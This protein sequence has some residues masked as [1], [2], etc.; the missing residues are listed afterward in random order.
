MTRYLAQRVLDRAWLSWDLRLENVEVKYALNGPAQISADLG[1][2]EL[3]AAGLEPW[4]SFIHVEEDGLI[5][6]SGVLMPFAYEGETVS[7]TAAG[8]TR[9]PKGIPYQGDFNLGTPVGVAIDPLDIVRHIWA[10][11]Q[12]HP[13]GNVGAIIPNL[14]TPVR[15]GSPERDVSFETDE[16]EQ[17]EFTAGPYNA[18]QWW[19][20]TDCGSEIDNLAEDTPFD[21]REAPRWNDSYT[22]VEQHVEFGYPRLGNLRTDLSFAEGE[23]LLQALV[24]VEA[25]DVYASEVI[26]LGKGEG[27]T[28]VRGRSGERVGNRLRRVLVVEDGTVATTDRAN[29]R[30]EAERL[31]RQGLLSFESVTIDARHPN[32]RLGSFA[33]GDDIPVR[34]FVPGV[35]RTLIHHRVL[36]YTWRPG[37]D[38]VEVEVDRSDT[39]QYGG[40]PA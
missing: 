7:I 2:E 12:G 19:E 4:G 31:R 39:F 36:S 25:D 8:V 14:T 27:V 37:V 26:V 33:P 34:C 28:T 29:Q 22:D 16:G 32:A 20:S 35:G 30:A 13:D 1:A 23:N 18:L 11:V 40:T 3:L 5:R 24:P 6:A 10:H 15:V 9:Y 21:Y 38:E 17:V